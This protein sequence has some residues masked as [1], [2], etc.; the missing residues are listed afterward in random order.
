MIMKKTVFMIGLTVFFLF[1][2]TACTS[3]ALSPGASS[4]NRNTTVVL[5][6]NPTTGYTWTFTI[7]RQDILALSSDKYIQN[8]TDPK[9]VGV[10]GQHT[11]VFEA[12]APGTATITFELGQQWAGGQKGAQTQKYQVTVGQD[13]NITSTKE[14]K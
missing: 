5:D 9:L 13:G 14:I 8:K 2:T 4:Q 3:A 7:D 6:E 12:K 11:Y 1:G 10:G